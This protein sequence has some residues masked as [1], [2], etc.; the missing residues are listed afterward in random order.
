[1]SDKVYAVEYIEDSE[2][3][4]LNQ[5]FDSLEEAEEVADDLRAQGW[6]GVNIIELQDW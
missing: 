6:G 5:T 2:L 3:T 4:G 1:M